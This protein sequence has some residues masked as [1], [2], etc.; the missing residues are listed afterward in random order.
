LQVMAEDDDIS[1]VVPK[2]GG[3]LWQDCMAIPN[4]APHPENAHK[5]INFILDAKVGADLADF[6]QYATPNEAAKKLMAPEY[7]NN[8][9][10]FP[11]DEVIARCEPPRYRGEDV[12][13]LLD[14][15]WTRIQ[16]A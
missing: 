5:F 2:E 15:A 1:Y 10:V 6:I 13:Q 16:A 14:A 8:P 3:E 4:G 7:V 9:A 11:T 12:I